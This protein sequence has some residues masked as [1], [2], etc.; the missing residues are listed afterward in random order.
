MQGLEEAR[1]EVARVEAFADVEE[2]EVE[3]ECEEAGEE[4]H[5]TLTED[6]SSAA[7]E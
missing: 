7:R 2:V 1:E 4:V 5:R 3:A 6:P